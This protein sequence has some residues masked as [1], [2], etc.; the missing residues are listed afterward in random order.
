MNCQTASVCWWLLLGTILF[1]GR[2]TDGDV[3]DD[4]EVFDPYFSL[5]TSPELPDTCSPV[6]RSIFGHSNDVSHVLVLT[7]HDCGLLR[8]TSPVAGE[9]WWLKRRQVGET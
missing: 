3:T 8:R 5:S 7:L 4:C 6:V 9:I 1:L 2:T